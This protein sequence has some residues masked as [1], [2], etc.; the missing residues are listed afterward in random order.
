MLFTATAPAD[1]EY[2]R[3]I[4]CRAAMCGCT[5]S[6]AVSLPLWR[7]IEM[8][9]PTETQERRDA[10]AEQAAHRRVPREVQTCASS[11]GEWTDVRD[12]SLELFD[13]PLVRMR[14]KI[15]HNVVID[16]ND[17]HMRIGLA[18]GVGDSFSLN[19]KRARAGDEWRCDM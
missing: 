2:R 8:L 19:R 7:V 3:C 14:C 1:G 6:L 10:L 4:T 16:G 15:T 9:Y 12:H 11:G 13:T 18:W 17:A 5:S